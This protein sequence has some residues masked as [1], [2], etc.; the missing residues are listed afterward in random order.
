M[1]FNFGYDQNDTSV[2]TNSD[3]K[4]DVNKDVTNIATGEKD[5]DNVDNVDPFDNNNNNNNES[6]DDEKDKSKQYEKGTTIEVDNKKYVVDENGNLLDDEGNIFKEAKDVKAWLDSFEEIEEDNNLINIKN[7]Q[8]ALGIDI[9]DDNDKV[10]EFENTP[11][12]IKSY[13]QAVIESAREENYQTAINSLYQKYPFVN[14]MINYYVT[15][16]N[17]LKG[18]NEVPDRS[19]ITIKDDDETQQEFIIRTA[20]KE[21]NRKG[22][23]DSYIEYL[24]SSGTLFD[25]AKEELIGLQ[26]SDAQRK[27]ELEK[28]AERIEE[29]RIKKLEAYWNGVH[30]VI[31]NRNIAG[32]KI[33]DSIIVN[34]NGQKFS[35]TPEDFFNYIYRVDENGKSAYEKDLAK[36]TA[37]SRRDDEILRAYLK[38]TGGNY[39][40]LVN[41]AI[42]EEKVK[43][44][45]YRAKERANN[46]IVRINKPQKDNKKDFD[47]GY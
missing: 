32:Y 15:N 26:E 16:G 11:E 13:V 3:K 27:A 7:I 20:W 45:K 19:N 23:V 30:E 24:K 1:D 14:D 34:R 5:N 40:N 43:T 22:N 12:G 9:T 6:K 10:I 46:T 41:M 18:Y 38:F 29:E 21:Q 37:E 42:N 2:E 31:N 33:P 8:E 28:E 4:D 25:T 36:E 47:F 39:S 17:S 44:L 35:V